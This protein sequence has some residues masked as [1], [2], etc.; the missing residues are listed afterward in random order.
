MIMNNFASWSQ[1]S[2]LIFT[3]MVLLGVNCETTKYA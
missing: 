1:N 3:E 2:L